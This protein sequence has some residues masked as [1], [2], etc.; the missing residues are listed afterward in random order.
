MKPLYQLVIVRFVQIAFVNTSSIQANVGVVIL[1]TY[2]SILLK[3][4][5][6]RTTWIDPLV[7]GGCYRPFS[8]VR[9]I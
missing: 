5:S 2:L 8:I 9:G 6:S 3:T 1:E 4:Y 7:V